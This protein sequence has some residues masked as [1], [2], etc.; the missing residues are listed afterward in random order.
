MKGGPAGGNTST[1]VYFRC[2]DCAVEAKRVPAHGG[3]V[4]KEKSPIGEFG[5]IVLATDTEG[6]MIGLHSM[7]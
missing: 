5:F 1:I 6:N 3:R 2:E 4:V 7:K